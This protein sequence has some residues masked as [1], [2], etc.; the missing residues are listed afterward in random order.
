MVKEME[1]AKLEISKLNELINNGTKQMNY[2]RT[3]KN[4]L[5][6]EIGQLRG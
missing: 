4:E 6:D 2:L 3:E 1:N 5:L